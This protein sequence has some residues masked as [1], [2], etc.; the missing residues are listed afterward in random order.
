ML[1]S[2]LPFQQIERDALRNDKIRKHAVR[3][4]PNEALTEPPK[5]FEMCP[6]WYLINL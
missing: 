5:H 6:Q 4:V 1:R 3:N 2:V